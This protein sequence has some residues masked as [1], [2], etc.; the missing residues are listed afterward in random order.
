MRLPLELNANDS[1]LSKVAAS[2]VAKLRSPIF[3]CS[4]FFAFRSFASSVS[5]MAMP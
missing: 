2:P 3:R 4:G 1:G 5:E